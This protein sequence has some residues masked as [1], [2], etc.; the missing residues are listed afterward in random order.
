MHPAAS[1]LRSVRSASAG[2]FQKEIGHCNA[3][4]CYLSFYDGKIRFYPEL[5]PHF[6]ELLPLGRKNR[7]IRVHF[8]PGKRVGLI[9]D[10]RSPFHNPVPEATIPHAKIRPIRPRISHFRSRP[11]LKN[12]VKRPDWFRVE[13]R[14]NSGSVF[15]NTPG[16]DGR[17]Q[18]LIAFG[19]GLF[20]AHTNTLA[21]PGS[22][23]GTRLWGPGGSGGF[24]DGGD[25]RKWGKSGGNVG[26]S[27][28]A[29]LYSPR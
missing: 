14:P 24:Y 8:G 15:R 2:T 13:T 10:H 28:Q 16:F 4:N 20:L 9:G 18:G 21:T 29:P 12:P 5:L 22:A 7:G 26:R 23:A 25:G 11:F 3:A 6:G 19:Q 27:T 17:Y 1:Y